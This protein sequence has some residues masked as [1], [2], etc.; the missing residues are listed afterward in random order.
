MRV[1]VIFTVGANPNRT[2]AISLKSKRYS[3]YLAIKDIRGGAENAELQR[4]AAGEARSQ[5]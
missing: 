3:Q 5:G 2:G 1:S 4:A